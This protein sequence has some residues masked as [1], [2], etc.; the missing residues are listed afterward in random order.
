MN[1][2]QRIELFNQT[3]EAYEKEGYTCEE[4]TISILKA[5]VMA[6][7]LAG[8]I[9]IVSSVIFGIINDVEGEI[10]DFSLMFLILFLISIVVHEGLHG[11]GW[12]LASEKGWKSIHFGVIWKALTPYCCCTEPMDSKKYLL[13]G[14]LP[15]AVLG[16]GLSIVAFVTGSVLIN[17]LAFISI[18]CAGGDLTI[19]I[20]LIKQRNKL[21]VDHPNKCGFYTFR[22]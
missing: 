5:N 15:L 11:L 3:R 9:A 18:I 19:M 2:E 20:M 13:G 16:F 17:S 22:K 6:L 14:A 4:H 12:S 10:H 7:L 21:I 1:E 8:P